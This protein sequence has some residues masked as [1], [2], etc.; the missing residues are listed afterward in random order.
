M[1]P[2]VI[3]QFHLHSL[4]DLKFES[5]NFLRLRFHHTLPS[6]LFLECGLSQSAIFAMFFCLPGL[7]QNLL[8][9]VRPAEASN[10]PKTS[11]STRQRTVY[12]NGGA[13]KVSVGG[14]CCFAGIVGLFEGSGL[15]DVSRS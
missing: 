3:L 12:V 6:D 4:F 9:N 2:C 8:Q 11:L 10:V 15:P 7:A 14:S 1:L 5:I 13:G